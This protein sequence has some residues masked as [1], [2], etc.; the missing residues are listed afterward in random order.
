ME[1]METALLS[2]G[3]GQVDPHI[4]KEPNDYEDLSEDLTDKEEEP[5]Q[6]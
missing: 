6:E 5:K 2:N 3:K 1:N 4:T